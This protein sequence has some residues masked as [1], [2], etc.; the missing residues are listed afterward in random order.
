MVRIKTYKNSS[1]MR[2][3]IKK[4]LGKI[5]Q[6]YLKKNGDVI[7]KPSQ[8]VYVPVESI[9]HMLEPNGKPPR[10]SYYKLA[11]I[12]VSV[13]V[14]GV[15]LDGDWDLNKKSINEL[16]AYTVFKERFIEG[17][18]WEETSYYEKYLK[19]IK[20]YGEARDFKTWGDL[21]EQVLNK[22]DDL[23]HQIKKHGYKKQNE[24]QDE[25]EIGVS[26]NGNLL[27]IDGRHRFAIAKILKIKEIPVVVNC[28]HKE[29]IDMV[30]SKSNTSMITPI[31]A[32]GAALDDYINGNKKQ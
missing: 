30:K 14:T 26:R 8:V 1:V 4:T 23:Y 5:N 28:W 13:R 16:L 12:T 32:I 10:R 25:I 31:S 21:K 3:L 17:K 15:I 6:Y 29:Y 19:R 2:G 27:F 9:T 24:P 20:A 18:E 11:N 7:E 22:W